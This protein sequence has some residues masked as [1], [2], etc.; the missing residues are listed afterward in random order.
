M[1]VLTCREGTEVR[2]RNDLQ[3][4]TSE[5][6]SKGPTPGT[7]SVVPPE[8]HRP[9]LEGAPKKGASARHFKEV[10][11]ATRRV[12]PPFAQQ[13]FAASWVPRSLAVAARRK[14]SPASETSAVGLVRTRQPLRWPALSGTCVGACTRAH[15]SGTGP[16]GSR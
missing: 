16:L 3:A 1:P 15:V 7:C 2:G 14:A 10:A 6:V 4:Q 13:V 5:P 12:I 8:P 9:W 11:S